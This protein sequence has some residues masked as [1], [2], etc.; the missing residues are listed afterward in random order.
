MEESDYCECGK[1]VDNDEFARQ[2]D[3]GCWACKECLQEIIADQGIDNL[4]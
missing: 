4:N 1:C 3:E 2:D